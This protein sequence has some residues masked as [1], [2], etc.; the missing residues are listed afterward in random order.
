MSGK[1]NTSIRD[2]LEQLEALTAWFESENFTL[3]EAMDKFREAEKL[4]GEIEKELNNFRHAI[5]VL[6]KDFSKD[7]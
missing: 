2:Q 3:E 1:S 6:K 5:T 7:V 4:A